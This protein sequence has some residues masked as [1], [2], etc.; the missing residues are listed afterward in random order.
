MVIVESAGLSDVGMKR[1]GNEDA[2]FLDDDLRLYIVADGMGGHQAGEVASDLVVR[3]ITDY[4]SRLKGKASGEIEEFE[5]ADKTLSKDANRLIAGISLS[6]KVVFQSAKAKRGYHGMGST[7]SAVYFTDDTLIATNVG[8]SPIYL[9]RSGDIEELSKPHTVLAEHMAMQ[10]DKGERFSKEYGHMLT[11][12]MGVE[13]TV[14]ADICEFPCFRGDIL[15]I[16]SDG[17]TNKVDKGEIA[18]TVTSQKAHKACQKL[19]EMANER[20][21]ED[22][23]TVIVAKVKSIQREKKGLMNL[24]SKLFH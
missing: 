22:N 13:E 19:V 24:F 15:V 10:G 2:F 14:R 20:G 21:G 17:L 3:T 8:D 5:D 9:I 6:N 7:V 11:R 18:K 12:A 4:M 16:A 23:I 1:R